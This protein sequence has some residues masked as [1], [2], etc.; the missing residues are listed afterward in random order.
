MNKPEQTGDRETSSK[1]SE[2]SS[3]PPPAR[4][5][6]NARGASKSQSKE[7]NGAQKRKKNK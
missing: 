7:G 3:M 2:T 4:G 1:T 5:G 6:S